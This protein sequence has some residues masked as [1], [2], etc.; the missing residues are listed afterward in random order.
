MQS[1]RRVSGASVDKNDN[2][3]CPKRWPHSPPVS[4]ATMNAPEIPELAPYPLPEG[5]RQILRDLA[6]QSEALFVGE[7]H[8]TQE[9]LRLPGNPLDPVKRLGGYGALALELPCATA[10]TFLAEPTDP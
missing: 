5:M 9:P 3:A 4:A 1:I 2:A 7:M 8:A 10:A 6:G